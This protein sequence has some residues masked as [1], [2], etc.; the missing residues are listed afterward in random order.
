VTAGLATERYAVAPAAAYALLHSLWQGAL[1]AVLAALAMSLL[2][3][4][5]AAVRHAVGLACLLAMI[6]APVATFVLYRRAAELAFPSALAFVM[7]TPSGRAGPLML[8]GADWLVLAVPV[9]WLAGAAV[10]VLRQLGGWRAVLAL[11]RRPSG[12]LP[13]SWLE[14]VEVLRR[15]LGIARVVSL[16]SE[17][18]SASPFTARMVRPVIW[19]PAALWHRLTPAQRDALLAHELAHV[20]RL[21]WLWNGLQSTAQA[22]LFFHPA[23]AWLSRRVRQEREHACDDLAV[24]TCG[25]PVA[26]AEG[27]AALE[28]QRRVR[29]ALALAAR[30]GSLVQRITRL[31]AGSPGRARVRVPLGLVVL[32]CAGTALAG[33]LELPNDVLIDLC[34]DAS[35]AGPLTPGTYRDITAD[36]FNEQRHYR[37]RM[38]DQG[39]VFESYEEDGRP[40]PIDARVRAWLGQLPTR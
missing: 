2:A 24:A 19:L 29:P 12:A 25:D 18:G 6:A 4:R 28:R 14:R 36:A 11:D 38:D 34:V 9:A 20:R 17:S 39:R 32:L 13:D 7:P 31:L 26:L 22:L 27:L 30:G 15:A 21:D 40:R 10:M 37:G 23:A 33:R 35:T 8:R 3:R 16:R 5:S 1:L